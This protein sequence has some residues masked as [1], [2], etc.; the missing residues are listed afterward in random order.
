MFNRKVDF[1]HVMSVVLVSIVLLSSGA[2]ASELTAN[3]YGSVEIGMEAEEALKHL[4]GYGFDKELYDEPVSC[5]YLTPPPEVPGVYFMINDG[6]VSRFDI[7]R[8]SLDVKTDRGVGVGSM[9]S[10]VLGAYPD[11][12]TSPHP[13]W[14]PEGEYLEITLPNG[15]GIIFET[16]H[17]VVT[18]Y[19]LGK[20][21]A[22]GYIEGCM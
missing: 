9:K 17:D 18:S 20:Y 5:Y 14:D 6:K 1:R 12:K 22:L 10:E 4:E 21:P 2:S 16:Y 7:D 8:N 15:Y 19:R 13:Y 11:L 3:A